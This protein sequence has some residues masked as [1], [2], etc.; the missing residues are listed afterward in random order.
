[1]PNTLY[2]IKC[3]F[4]K[5]YF[6]LSAAFFFNLPLLAQQ[7]RNMPDSL[8]RK[9]AFAFIGMKDLNTT[10]YLLSDEAARPLRYTAHIATGVCSDGLCKPVDLVLCWDLLGNFE[11]YKTP[12][13]SP[14]TKFDHIEFTAEDHKKLKKILADKSSMLKD[15]EAEDM[16]DK[17][18]K[19]YS[20]KLDAVTGATSK[21]FQDVIVPGAVYT[22]HTLWHIAN[23]PVSDRILNYT[24]GLLDDKLIRQM[25]KSD[26]PVY[27]DFIFSQ[28]SQT[29]LSRFTAELIMLIG[30]KDP[31]V[32]HF[33]MAK[34][35]DEVW[36]NPVHQEAILKYFVSASLEVQNAM[37]HKLA[38]KK[39]NTNGLRLMTSA[40]TRLN[41]TQVQKLLIIVENNKS[42]MTEDLKKELLALKT[43]T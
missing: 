18:V 14:L 15:Y 42:S 9:E 11:S 4:P 19:V 37:L 33:A 36:N 6:I 8:I 21:T 7:Q 23:G 38:D 10:V 29:E 40:A 26:R 1:M 12:P 34:L 43:K 27:K 31:F 5:L 41:K 35:T 39:L 20:N 30:D 16:V 2:Q 28:L 22:V 17:T 3:L 32:P 24:K 13:G 25:L